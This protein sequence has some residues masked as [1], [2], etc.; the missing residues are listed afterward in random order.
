MGYTGVAKL[1]DHSK[2]PN[3]WRIAI[4]GPDGKTAA[5]DIKG[6]RLMYDPVFGPDA[7]DVDSVRIAIEESIE[8][9]INDPM[10]Q[11]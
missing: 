11:V 3:E 2:M 10:S 1:P 8:Q 6:P 7:Q 9:F 4:H 5:A